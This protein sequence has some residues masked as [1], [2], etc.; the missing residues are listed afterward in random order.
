MIINWNVRLI[1]VRDRNNKKKWIGFICTD[2]S[3]TEE[4]IIALYRKRWDIVIFN[5]FYVHSPIEG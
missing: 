4:Q 2:L 5:M 3:L 1:F